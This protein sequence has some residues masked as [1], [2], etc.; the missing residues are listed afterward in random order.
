MNSFFCIVEHPLV[1]QFSK[2]SGTLYHIERPRIQRREP[3]SNV[4]FTELFF[5]VD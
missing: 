5:K 3:Q 1:T 4:V 2:E